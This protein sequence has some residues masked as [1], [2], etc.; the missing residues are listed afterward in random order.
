MDAIALNKCKR[1]NERLGYLDKNNERGCLGVALREFI[2]TS[3]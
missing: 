1:I 2:V 3:L